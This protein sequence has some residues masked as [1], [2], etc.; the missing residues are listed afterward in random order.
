MSAAKR[1]QGFRFRASRRVTP[2]HCGASS[3]LGL[4]I[5]P[6]APGVRT[7]FGRRFLWPSPELGI[8]DAHLLGAPESF[9]S[10]LRDASSQST[11]APG[12]GA[13]GE[14][15]FLVAPSRARHR[16]RPL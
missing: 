16:R 6:R 13:A 12:G 5:C 2:K 4:Q 7:V 14:A 1:P 8:G 9:D 15:L 3:K 10:G 11:R